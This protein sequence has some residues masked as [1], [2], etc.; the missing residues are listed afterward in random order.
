MRKGDFKRAPEP[1]EKWLQTLGNTTG[2]RIARLGGDVIEYRQLL[3]LPSVNPE[4]QAIHNA[5]IHDIGGT[6]LRSKVDEDAE[7]VAAAERLR[8]KQTK[9]ALIL[10]KKIKVTDF[11]DGGLSVSIDQEWDTS[12]W[13]EELIRAGTESL[14]LIFYQANGSATADRK[15][16]ALYMLQKLLTRHKEAE[17]YIRENVEKFIGI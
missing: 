10:K 5:Y 4:T 11:E 8:K 7:E 14:I 13:S 15:E 9:L 12:T 1:D 17:M 2:D 6:L 3:G 16:R